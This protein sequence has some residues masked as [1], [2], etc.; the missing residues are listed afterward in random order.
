MQGGVKQND[1]TAQFPHGK[2]EGGTKHENIGRSRE[3][4]KEFQKARVFLS[5]HMRSGSQTKKN[6]GGWL[7][8]E[9]A[10]SQKHATREEISPF[11]VQQ[12]KKVRRRGEQ[13]LSD[14]VETEKNAEESEC[15]SIIY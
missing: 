14:E 10:T 8:K 5:M 13:D 15:E 2:K 3:Q 12:R 11:D 1:A 7:D 6:N 9:G 4:S